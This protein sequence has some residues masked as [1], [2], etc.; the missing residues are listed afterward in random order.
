MSIDMD[1]VNE[2]IQSNQKY[3]DGPPQLAYAVQCAD[4]FTVSMQAGA[5]LYCLP[6]EDAG[7]PYWQV[8]LGYPSEHPGDAIMEFIDGGP[9]DD[10]TKTVFGYVPV[11]LVVTLLEAHGGIAG[12]YSDD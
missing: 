8:E 6:R 2:W 10:P 3:E 11:E 5:C 1:I 4:G 9:G 12:R 7:F